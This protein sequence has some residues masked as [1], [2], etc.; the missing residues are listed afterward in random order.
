MAR[1][2]AYLVPTTVTYAALKRQ[3]VEAGMPPE[4]VAK[5]GDAVERGLA[6]M[7][8]AR[9]HEVTMC[10]GSDLLG[11]MHAHQVGARGRGAASFRLRPTH[12]P[13]V[14]PAL[15]TPHG[16]RNPQ[17][18]PP[19]TTPSARSLSCGLRLASLP[20]NLLP[21]PPATALSCLTGCVSVLRRLTAA[22]ATSLCSSLTFQSPGQALVSQPPQPKTPTP[23]PR[24]TV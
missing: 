2:R 8:L 9:E 4:L 6:S 5:V 20:A 1:S 13:H 23:T 24:H 16:I 14:Q 19:V 21:M 3:G 22:A 18:P 10:F 12:G 7:S 11:D 17:L 15:D